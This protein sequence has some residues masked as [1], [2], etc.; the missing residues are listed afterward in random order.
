LKLLPWS[1]PRSRETLFQQI[2]Q[3]LP[4]G[5]KVTTW[6]QRDVDYDLGL[7]KWGIEIPLL[8]AIPMKQFCA[9]EEAWEKKLLEKY[10]GM[11]WKDPDDGEL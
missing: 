7:E 3:L 8:E 9:Y 11:T 4:L 2:N 6:G 5:D 1:L 10:G